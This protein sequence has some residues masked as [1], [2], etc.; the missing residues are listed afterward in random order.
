MGVGECMCLCVQVC[1]AAYSLETCWPHGPQMLCRYPVQSKA[2]MG[3]DMLLDMLLLVCM[4]VCVCVDVCVRVPCDATALVYSKVLY[5]LSRSVSSASLAS[6]CCWFFSFELAHS[7]SSFPC[8]LSLILVCPCVF[9]RGCVYATCSN[10]S[11]FL[12][13]LL[14]SPL[15]WYPVWMPL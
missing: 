7:T 15:P 1:L 6:L 13:L 12:P 11:L 4:Y 5:V 3:L 10:S 8:H 2:C 9:R 14:L